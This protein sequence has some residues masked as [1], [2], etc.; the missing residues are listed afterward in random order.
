MRWKEGTRWIYVSLF[1]IYPYIIWTPFVLKE[2]E[3]EREE[4]VR[5]DE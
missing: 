3:R 4:D 5:N 1:C 2:R